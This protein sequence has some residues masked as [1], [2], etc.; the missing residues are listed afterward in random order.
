MQGLQVRAPEAAPAQA[1]GLG[2]KLVAQYGYS[3]LQFVV[4]DELIFR[5]WLGGIDRPLCDLACRH[6]RAS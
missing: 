1:S 2:R 4:P 6:V 3:A 5:A